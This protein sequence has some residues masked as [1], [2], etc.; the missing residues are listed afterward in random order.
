MSTDKR[1]VVSACLAGVYCRYN[2]EQRETPEVIRLVEQG[3]A[4]P[5]CP[6]QLGGLPT[7]RPPL[8]RRGDRVVD[9]NGNDATGEFERGAREAL[10]LARMAGCTAA[11]LQARSPSCG[12][13]RIYD[14]TFSGALIPG[15]GVFA[16]LCREA[17]L[18]LLAPEDL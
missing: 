9:K 17:G 11:V 14:G 18:E 4:L 2:G 6:E 15:D 7:P 8:E 5:V 12:F 10:R 16:A 3:R 1:Y 13:G